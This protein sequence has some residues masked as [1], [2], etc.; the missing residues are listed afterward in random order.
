MSSRRLMLLEATDEEK[1]HKCRCNPIEGDNYF[2]Y[3]NEHDD[4]FDAL[5]L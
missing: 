2:I 1:E 4:R 3:T 5:Y